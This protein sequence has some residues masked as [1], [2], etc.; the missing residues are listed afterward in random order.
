M[1]GRAGAGPGT[2]ESGM[3]GEDAGSP[4]VIGGGAG[5]SGGSAGGGAGGSGGGRSGDAGSAGSG[6]GAVLTGCSLGNACCANNQCQSSL[7]CLGSVCSCAAE[8]SGTY[9]LR[10]DG[11]AFLTPLNAVTQ[12]VVFN[13]DTAQP[14][15]GIV[16]IASSQYHG[17]AALQTGEVR[18]WPLDGSSVGNN[19]GQLG[20]GK[21]STGTDTNPVLSATLVKTGPTSNLGK[22]VSVGDDG[23]TYG[24]NTT[25]CAVTSDK[26][27]YCW[28]N[29]APR[30]IGY[31]ATPTPYATKITTSEGGPELTGVVGVS[32]GAAAAC[33]LLDTGKIRCWGS[34]LSTPTA[35]QHYPAQDFTV[36][37]T[38]TKVLA[39]SGAACALNAAGS[40]YCWGGGASLGIGPGT[41]NSD[42]P[43]RVSISATTFLEG[44]TDVSI[45]Y[46]GA[47]ALRNDHTVWCW[48]GDGNTS[49]PYATQVR[50]GGVVTGTGAFVTDAVKISTPFFPTSPR[51]LTQSGVEYAQTQMYKPNCSPQE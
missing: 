27:L 48:G 46:G 40:V 17:C 41:M 24:A 51:Y 11:I 47:C 44:V 21:V 50:V 28:G 23:S 30:L 22:V 16:S 8:L 32:V 5:G 39:G 37:G 4:G 1:D 10:T 3:P 12:S 2:G 36:P 9:M 20:N 25:T 31:A 7:N 6:G 35:L 49:I 43:N 26:T 15:H 29:G 19:S 42:S 45:A 38:V 14:L 13:A 34:S 18:C 33:V